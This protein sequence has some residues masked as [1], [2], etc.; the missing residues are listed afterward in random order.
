VRHLITGGEIRTPDRRVRYQAKINA[1]A[2]Q[3]WSGSAPN[4]A[5]CQQF[6]WIMGRLGAERAR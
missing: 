6:V 1:T 3:L 5:T 2:A 4:P